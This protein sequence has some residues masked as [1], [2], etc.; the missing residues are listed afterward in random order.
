M[1]IVVLP[2]ILLMVGLAIGFFAGKSANT[3]A[4]EPQQIKTEVSNKLFSGQTAFLRG[5]INKVDEKQISV[6]NTSTNTTGTVMLSDRAIIINPNKNGS[7][8]VN[9]GSIE[10]DKEALI[11]LEMNNGNYEI[12]SIQYVNPAPSLTP[13]KEI[14]PISS[15]SATNKN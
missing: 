9:I 8:S 1:K 11:N 3:K 12:I 6:T 2:I 4:P 15:Q 10:L 7:P 14:K 5:K 13:A